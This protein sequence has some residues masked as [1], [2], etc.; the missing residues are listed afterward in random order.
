MEGAFWIRSLQTREAS[1]TYKHTLRALYFGIIQ[2]NVPCHVIY[3]R[4]LWLCFHV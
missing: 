2:K 1:A 4:D 3:N